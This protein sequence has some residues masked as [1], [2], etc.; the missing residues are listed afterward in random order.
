M[1]TGPCNIQYE[2]HGL[3]LLMKE[4]RI[5]GTKVFSSCKNL[6]ITYWQ[7]GRHCWFYSTAKQNVPSQMHMHMHTGRHDWFYYTS[8]KCAIP[9]DMICIHLQLCYWPIPTTSEHIAGNTH[10]GYARMH[11]W[12]AYECV[13]KYVSMYVCMYLYTHT[14][15][16]THIYMLC[17][18]MMCVICMMCMIRVTCMICMI[19]IYVHAWCVS[20]IYAHIFPCLCSVYAGTHSHACVH[21]SIHAYFCMH[22]CMRMHEY[23]Y[24]WISVCKFSSNVYVLTDTLSSMCEH[25]RARVCMSE[26]TKVQLVLHASMSIYVCMCAPWCTCLLLITF[27]CFLGVREP[28][29]VRMRKYTHMRMRVI[30]SWAMRIASHKQATRQTNDF[31]HVWSQQCYDILHHRLAGKWRCAMP[32]LLPSACRH[33]GQATQSPYSSNSLCSPLVR[34]RLPVHHLWQ[35]LAPMA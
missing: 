33:A 21:I 29:E 4:S 26:H 24:A 3:D 30:V 34:P 16:H 35:E 20:L 12:S 25:A 5:W 28:F 7:A 13:C 23:L 22:A 18:C 10:A 1:L 32:Q 2:N 17:M 11:A 27:A 14:H 9:D 6:L 15:T 19:Y 8:T 31:V